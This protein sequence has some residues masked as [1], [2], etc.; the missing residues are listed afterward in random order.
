MYREREREI[1]MFVRPGLT[2][3]TQTVRLSSP[4]SSEKITTEETLAG[5]SGGVVDYVYI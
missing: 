1:L 4:P 5:Q 2:P 3:C